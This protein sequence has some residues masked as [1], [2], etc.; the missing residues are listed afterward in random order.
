MEHI[1]GNQEISFVIHNR[2][3]IESHWYK[4]FFLQ[5]PEY[6]FRLQKGVKNE[7]ENNFKILHIK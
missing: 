1:V 6:R 3:L 5:K 2:L 7:D 4:L